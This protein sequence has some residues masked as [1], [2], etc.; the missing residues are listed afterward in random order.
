MKHIIIL[1]FI[2]LSSCT[3]YSG[4][5]GGYYSS[6]TITT[7][8]TIIYS[9]YRP[10]RF[11]TYRPYWWTYRPN[12]LGNV[13]QNSNTYTPP[14]NLTPRTNIP[15]NGTGTG[16]YGGRGNQGNQSGGRSGPSGGRRK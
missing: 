15:F 3:I 11:W 5:R 6:Q 2:S 16:V 4:Y 12:Y 8:P 10:W 9:D 14:R 7:E 1:L 13:Y